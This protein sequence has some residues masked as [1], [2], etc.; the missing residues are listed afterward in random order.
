MLRESWYLV[1]VCKWST[2]VSSEHL[3]SQDAVDYFMMHLQVIYDNGMETSNA[4]EPFAMQNTTQHDAEATSFNSHLV[5]PVNRGSSFF[6]FTCSWCS[7]TV[8]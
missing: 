4:F 3:K 5:F 7:L 8:S 2:I 1:S 6:T